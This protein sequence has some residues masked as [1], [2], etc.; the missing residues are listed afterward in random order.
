[1]SGAISPLLY[2]SY[3]A[4]INQAQEQLYVSFHIN[5]VDT[6]MNVCQYKYGLYIYVC[7]LLL[8][9]N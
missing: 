2:T 8:E 9:K 1:M 4:V 6:L 3:L 5:I 7:N